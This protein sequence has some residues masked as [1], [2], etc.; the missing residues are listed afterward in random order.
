MTALHALTAIMTIL[1]V[2]PAIVL[3]MVPGKIDHIFTTVLHGKLSLPD[4]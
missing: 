1:S 3:Q 4:S 2:N